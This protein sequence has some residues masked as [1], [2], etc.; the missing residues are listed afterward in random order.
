MVPNVKKVRRE[1]DFVV[2]GYREVFDQGSIPILL[3]WSPILIATKRAEAGGCPVISD[4]RSDREGAGI[5]V[6]LL[7]ITAKAGADAPRSQSASKCGTG[8]ETCCGV[9]NGCQ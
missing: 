1:L 4:D 8:R 9:R 5:E 2:L 7:T 6:G 3:E